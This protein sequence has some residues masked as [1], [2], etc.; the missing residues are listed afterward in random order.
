M[1]DLLET[2]GGRRHVLGISGGRDS[3]ALAV[4]MRDRVPG[5]EY[6]FCDTGSELPETYE[7]L[8]RLEAV[9]GK[10]IARLTAVPPDA[11]VHKEPQDQASR[12]LDRRG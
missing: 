3:A 11:L 1:A 4:Y 9:L 10:S 6:F 5:M 12:G 8:K 7:Y 2:G